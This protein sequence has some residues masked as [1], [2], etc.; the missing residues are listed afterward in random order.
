MSGREA[1]R[2]HTRRGARAMNLLPAPHPT[3]TS[4]RDAGPAPSRSR[5][6]APTTTGLLADWLARYAATGGKDHPPTG[7]RPHDDPDAVPRQSTSTTRPA[8]CAS[9][10]S[11]ATPTASSPAAAA[12]PAAA[13]S[14]TS[15]PTLPM[16][17]GG[18]PGQTNA[19]QSCAPVPV[20]P[21]PQDP[22][23]LGLQDRSTTA[24]LHSGPHPPATST[25]ST[26]PPA[27]HPNDPGEEP[28]APPPRPT[29]AGDTGT[30]RHSDPVVST[31]S[32]SVW[33]RLHFDPRPARATATTTVERQHREPDDGAGDAAQPNAHV[34]HTPR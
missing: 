20:P 15:P 6:S 19:S 14:T 12:T 1:R 28:D 33:R 5:S 30:P 31:S 4:H 22:H 2:P 27:A 10:A 11:C 3:T 32:T 21:P 18:P 24:R 29:P 16:A 26:P 25:P 8:Q 13:T 17:D 9:S 34:D 7:H 23:R